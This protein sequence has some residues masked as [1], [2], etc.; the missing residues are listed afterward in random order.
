MATLGHRCPTIQTVANSGE[1]DR[2]YHHG[3]LK[4]AVVEAALAEIEAVGTSELSMREVARRAGVSHAAPAHHFGDKAGIFTEI[5]ARGFSLLTQ[6][7]GELVSG[8][9]VEA[10]AGYVRFALEHKAHFE[11]MFRP[12]LYRTDDPELVAARD[13]SF[14]VLYRAVE[15][16]LQPG[17]E[18]ELMPTSVAAWSAL[19]GFATLLLYGNL[20][21]KL[22]DIEPLEVYLVE[23][24]RGMITLGEIIARQ[25]AGRPAARNPQS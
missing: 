21:P 19:H 5:A 24:A 10:A 14:E 13:S 20:E 6:E 17:Q 3:R 23:V 12:E 7:T 22:G 16:G 25:E 8:G 1:R 18:D 2:P 9:L 11:V 4:E 15:E